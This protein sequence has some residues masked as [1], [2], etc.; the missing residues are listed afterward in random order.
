M[1][2][3]IIDTL[4]ILLAIGVAARCIINQLETHMAALD[5]AIKSLQTQVAAETTVEQSAITLINGIPALIADAV[6]KAQAQGVT[7]E[8]LQ[9][10]TDLQSTI[11]SNAA[12]LGAAVTANTPAA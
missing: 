10:L 6:A 4:L 9:A 3:E 7:P 12:N 11:A 8:Q 2:I 5:D 1:T